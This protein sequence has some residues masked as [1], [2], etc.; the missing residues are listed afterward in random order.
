MDKTANPE[1]VHADMNEWM[2]EYTA[3]KW[4]FTK[5]LRSPDDYLTVGDKQF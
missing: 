3:D 5:H 2:N 1:S 4:V